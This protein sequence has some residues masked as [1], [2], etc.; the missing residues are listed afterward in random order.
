ML[1][2]I[3]YN[4]KEYEVGRNYDIGEQLKKDYGQYKLGVCQNGF[5]TDILFKSNNY[6]ESD[7]VKNIGTLVYDNENDIITYL[8][9]INDSHIMK[10]NNSIGLN[11]D[12]VQ[13]LAVKDKIRIVQKSE[14]EIIYRTISVRKALTYENYKQF[15]TQGYERQ[16]F[17]PV[18]EFKSKTVLIGGKGK[19][20]KK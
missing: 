4:G 20:C 2:K 11:F 8:K 16:I 18:E 1:R 13:N 17:I 9:Y 5:R 15:K 6:F 14:K 12:V 10:V 19:K 7:K 3:I